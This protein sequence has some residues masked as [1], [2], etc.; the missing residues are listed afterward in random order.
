M[1]IRGDPLGLLSS[2]LFP[3][4]YRKVAVFG[5]A[6]HCI[7]DA[8]RL[9]TCNDGG[10]AAAE[11]FYHDVATI[12]VHFDAS[13]RQLHREHGRVI[14]IGAYRVHLPDAS[15]TEFGNGCN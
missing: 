3:A 13:P 8:L 9:L 7:A 15:V 12:G 10:A 6:L 2:E 5:A 1:A 11:R 14:L 4:F